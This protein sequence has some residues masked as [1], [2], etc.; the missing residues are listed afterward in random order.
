MDDEGRVLNAEW[1]FHRAAQYIW[2]WSRTDE[3]TVVDP[4]FE[5]WELELHGP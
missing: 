5:A 3:I 2:H 4:P 1:A